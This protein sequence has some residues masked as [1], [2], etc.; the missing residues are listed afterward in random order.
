[1]DEG[2][3]IVPIITCDALTGTGLSHAF[4]TRAGGVSAGV[5]ASLNGGTGS[6]DRADAVAENRAR[7]ARALGLAPDRLLVPFQIH[8]SDAVSVSAPWELD[9]RPRADAIV[10]ATNGLA[11]AVTGAD[12]GIVLLVDATTRVIGASH[13]GW[14]GALAGIIEAT[15]A[16]MEKLGAKRDRICAALGPTIGP[17][18]Y[19]V[20]SEFVARFT[21]DASDNARFF[22]P[23]KR[24]DHAFF[25]LPSYIGMRARVA[26]C[27][28]FI[29]L[30]LDTY[31]DEARFF[32][33]RRSVH[34]REPDYG[35]LVAAI[36]LPGS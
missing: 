22:T 20:G 30:G 34:R 35:R 36:A 33:Y 7:M 32:S 29:D 1:M 15:L 31:A 23:S 16:A 10:T 28:Q 12:C 24:P 11:V 18:S 9:Q 3:P 13:A 5:Y 4:F 2:R 26:G 6:R 21:A 25:D 27:G 14:K 17:S 19:E 8:S